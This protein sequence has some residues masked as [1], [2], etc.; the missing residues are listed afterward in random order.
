MQFN[1]LQFDQMNEEQQAVHKH[2]CDSPRGRRETL[3][4]PQ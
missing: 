1:D 2:A 3:I 4:C